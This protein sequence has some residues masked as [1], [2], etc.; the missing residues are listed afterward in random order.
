MALAGLTLAL[1][2]AFLAQDWAQ[3]ALGALLRRRSQALSHWMAPQGWFLA[4]L[5]LGGV[6]VLLQEVAPPRRLG[7][8]LVLGALGLAGVLALL[9]RVLQPAR[10]RRS[11]AVAALLL[12]APALALGCLAFG[13]SR[14]ALVFWAWPLAYY[15]AATLSAQS[16][17]RG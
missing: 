7:L 12:A 14:L 5:S 6:L 11:L 1:L 2:T 10:G 4:G 8:A 17:I 9:A 15:P 16:F 13:P 3:A